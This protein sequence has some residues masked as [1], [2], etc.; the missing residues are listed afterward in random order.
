MAVRCMSVLRRAELAPRA[1]SHT[2]RFPRQRLG[3][4][5]YS[6]SGGHAP[7]MPVYPSPPSLLLLS[8]VA[9]VALGR[10]GRLENLDKFLSRDKEHENAR[11]HNDESDC[12]W[13]GD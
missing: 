8:S 6:S 2:V 1:D 9:G 7:L 12:Y 3:H 10:L 4:S 5:G 13:P 11:T